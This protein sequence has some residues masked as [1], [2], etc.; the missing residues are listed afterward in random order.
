MPL[1]S[2]SDK[3][4]SV[5]KSLNKEKSCKGQP[6]VDTEAGRL[7]KITF[8]SWIREERFQQQNALPWET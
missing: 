2:D 7:H 8:G 5:Q 6:T 1:Q 4:L 3:F